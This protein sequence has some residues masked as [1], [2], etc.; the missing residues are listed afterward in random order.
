MAFILGGHMVVTYRLYI[1]ILIWGSIIVIAISAGSQQQ[2]FI[3]Y[4]HMLILIEQILF[5]IIIGLF[6]FFKMKFE[7]WQ[8]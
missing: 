7:V 3:N 1:L 2:M 6:T 5:K 8:V 4:H